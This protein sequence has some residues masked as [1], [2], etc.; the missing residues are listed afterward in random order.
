MRKIAVLIGI[1]L[2]APLAAHA[3]KN[4]IFAGYSFMR[5]E[6]AP[7]NIFI[8][9]WEGSY[10]RLFSQYFGIEGDASGHYGSSSGSRFNFHSLYGGAQFRLPFRYSPFV[11]VM[12]GDTRLSFQGIVTNKVSV[13]DGGGFDYRASDDF[14]VRLIQFDYLTGLHTQIS[15]EFRVSTGII[16]RF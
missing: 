1:F 12:L 9:G 7:S 4:E 15:P 3:Q 10:T 14:Y 2:L 13:A 5:M 6:A 8:N 11:H 16:I